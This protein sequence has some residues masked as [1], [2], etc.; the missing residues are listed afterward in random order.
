MTHAHLL[1]L[2]RAAALA[3]GAAI[4]PFVGRPV[5]AEAKADGS[6]LTEADMA[7]HHAILGVLGTSGLPVLSEESA[8][9]DLAGAEEWTRFWCVDPLDGT[10]EFVAGRPEF[11]VNVALIEGGFPVLGVVHVP[12][13]GV[14]YGGSAAG[15]WKE[16]PGEARRVLSLPDDGAALPETVVVVASRSHAGPAVD[17]ILARIRADG[18]TVETAALGSSLKFCLVAEGAADLYPRTGPTNAW[19]T[20]AAQAVVEAAGGHVATWDGARL[21]VDPARPLNPPVV[22]WRAEGVGRA[23]PRWAGNLHGVPPS[24]TA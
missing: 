6:P 9:G 8:E 2:A 21:G 15:A 7:A 17:A 5:P 24:R 12:V 19:D 14:T 20:A 1:D 11:T 18:H 4:A 22:T 10:K 16:T 13:S 23:W 3:G